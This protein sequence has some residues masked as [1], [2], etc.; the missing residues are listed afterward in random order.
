MKIRQIE[1]K[2]FGS[3][4]GICHFSFESDNRESRIVIIGGK[5][6]AGK[7]TLFSAIQLCLYGF[8]V[9]GYKSATKL[10]FKE[11]KH[12]INNHAILNNQETAYVRV[13][14]QSADAREINHY[15]VERQWSWASESIVESLRVIKDGVLLD[16]DQVA[17]FENYLIHLI[18]PDLLRLYFFDGEK[19]ADYFLSEQKINI[20]NAL[21]IL[22]GNDTFD[23]L[24]ANV[25]RIMSS[26]QVH[27]NSCSARYLSLRDDVNHLEESIAGLNQEYNAANDQLSQIEE[28]LQQITL[29]YAKSGGLT[30]VQ[31][32]II[33]RELRSEEERREQINLQRKSMATDILPFLILEDLVEQILPQ[34]HNEE[35]YQAHVVLS[36]KLSSLELQKSW[37]SILQKAGLNSGDARQ[38]A[39]NALSSALLESDKEYP[40]PLFQLSDDE[41][42]QI[43]SVM[44]RIMAF[45]RTSFSNLQLQLEESIKK[46]RLL[47][48]QLQATD[49]EMMKNQASSI[50]ALEESIVKQQELLSVLNE[51]IDLNTQ[52]LSEKKK[53]LIVMR[54][55]LENELKCASVA[56]I[57]G[58][59]LLL[60]ESLQN[61]L[62]A[63]MVKQVEDDLNKKFRELVRKPDFFERIIVDPDF[64]VHIIRKE[65]IPLSE[66]KQ[67]YASGGNAGLYEKLGEDAVK[68]L[69][70]VKK[71]K[72][73]TGSL[74][75]KMEDRAYRLPMEYDKDRMSS[76]EKQIFVMALYYAIMQQSGNSLPFV[77]DTPFARIDTEHRANIT[78]HFFMELPGQLIILS[79]NEELNDDH[80]K[81]MKDQIS[82]VYLLDYSSEQRTRI[83]SDTYFEE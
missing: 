82:R 63:S 69:L 71:A 66:I 55:E 48:D 32:D 23:I 70:Y 10:Y 36:E 19:I 75:D 11:I 9:Y 78:E 37:H 2:N 39:I 53:Q 6:G 59:L 56:S 52:L 7:T 24:H 80:I 33:Q 16:R 25:R 68:E 74:L 64:N 76:G 15:I 12:V 58:K 22:S 79:T 28:Q 26:T 61:A 83:L 13:C 51:K 27:D 17:D 38:F 35:I 44:T 29:Q 67:I 42:M 49:Y 30:D 73:I 21:M 14:F 54:K 40:P 60:L 4:E 81:I 45:D 8:H 47:R 31:C 62:Y 41:K 72:K 77:I 34:I 1:L 50:T 65:L 3:Y 5:N 46:S 57:S 18:P 43:H 20:R